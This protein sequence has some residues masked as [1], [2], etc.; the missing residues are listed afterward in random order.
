MV[1]TIK[2]NIPDIAEENDL[3]TSSCF[4]CPLSKKLYCWTYC[5]FLQE[6]REDGVVPRGCPLK[7]KNENK[8]YNFEYFKEPN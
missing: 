2:I 3:K 6:I 8:I 4:D 1:A 7:K 5:P